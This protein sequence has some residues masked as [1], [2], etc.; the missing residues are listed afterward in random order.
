MIL[1]IKKENFLDLVSM[2]RD[3]KGFN[4]NNF[5]TFMNTC[6]KYHYGKY[7]YYIMKKIITIYTIKT[8][9]KLKTF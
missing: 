9:K 8:H 6:R 3:L 5:N 2:L 7:Y 4:Y 1:L